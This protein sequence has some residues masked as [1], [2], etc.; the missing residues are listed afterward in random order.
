M[1]WWKYSDLD[2][3]ST[4]EL[5]EALV[6]YHLSE[7]LGKGAALSLYAGVEL[8]IPRLKRQLCWFK[9]VCEDLNRQGDIFHA[10][11]MPKTAAI[12]LSVHIS[13]TKSLLL[14]A[15]LM[16]QYSRGLR[17]REIL[18][19]LGQAIS[20]PEENVYRVCS[21]TLGMYSKTKSGR[22]EFVLIQPKEQQLCYELVR[23]LKSVTPPAS[24]VSRNTSVSAYSKMITSAAEELNLPRYTGHSPRAGF[25]SDESLRGVPTQIIKAT[26][27]HT[28]DK[29]LA[30]YIDSVNHLVQVSSGPLV[31]WVRTAQYIENHPEQFFPQL[32]KGSTIN[33]LRA[34][35]VLV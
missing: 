34:K 21:L 28:S 15:C 14:G 16:V 18:T 30:V 3:E 23:W 6:T 20:L 19:L 27:R 24:N 9:L 17:P 26:T 11:G 25:V 2:I 33:V 5:D 13:Q 35:N 7:S 12:I 4:R 1:W 31:E 10:L 8:A 22:P 32:S 29:S